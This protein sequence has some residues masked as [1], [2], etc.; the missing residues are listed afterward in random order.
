MSVLQ[1]QNERRRENMAF[2]QE[3]NGG[4]NEKIAAL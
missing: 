2:F 3:Q 1:E 4:P